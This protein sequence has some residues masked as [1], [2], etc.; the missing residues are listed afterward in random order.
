MPSG[1]WIAR[2]KCHA[3]RNVNSCPKCDLD[4][5]ETLLQLMADI[6]EEQGTV[7]FTLG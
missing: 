7:F 5:K 1:V 4:K 6:R 2:G 3:I